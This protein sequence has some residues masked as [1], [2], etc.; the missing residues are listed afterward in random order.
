LLLAAAVDDAVE[1]KQ[2]T[3]EGFSDVAQHQS[4]TFVVSSL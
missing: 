4:S 1:G 2:T 3:A